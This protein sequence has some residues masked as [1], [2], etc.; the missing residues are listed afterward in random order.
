MNTQFS[1]LLARIACL[2]RNRPKTDLV[3]AGLPPVG[4]CTKLKLKINKYEIKNVEVYFFK[5]FY[6]N[7]LFYLGQMSYYS[8]F[9]TGECEMMSTD[10][11]YLFD[12]S[13]LVYYIQGDQL[14]SLFEEII[15]K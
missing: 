12:P 4:Q 5:T 9:Q 13:N 2:R 14:V 11:Y 15:N 8:R 10:P 7:S 3:S 1:A 6:I